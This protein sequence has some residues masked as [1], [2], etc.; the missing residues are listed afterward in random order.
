MRNL[1]I[2]L[3]LAVFGKSFAQ[4]EV[5][6][7]DTKVVD[8]LVYYNN[9]PLT[10][11]LFS[12]DEQLVPNACECTLRIKYENGL[13]NGKYQEWNINGKIKKE[14][15]Y[16]Q[17][18]LQQQK[19]Y[20]ND[21][22]FVETHY[23]SGKPIKEVYYKDGK[24]NKIK[25]Y[26][27][28][29][30]DYTITYYNDKL[31]I[32]KKDF[33][34]NNKLY[35]TEKPFD[36]KFYIKYRKPFESNQ[37]TY[38]VTFDKSFTNDSLKKKIHEYIK[39]RTREIKTDD[40]IGASYQLNFKMNGDNFEIALSGKNDA[41]KNENSFKSVKQLFSKIDE[42]FPLSCRSFSIRKQNES[43]IQ[44]IELGKGSKEGILK[45][46]RLFVYDKNN[47]LKM[48]ELKVIQAYPHKSVCKVISYSEWLKKYINDNKQILVIQ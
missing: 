19:V 43:E 45:K 38:L 31:K 35:K 48:S 17:G 46:M 16:K 11:V 18:V 33:F 4:I 27:Q 14:A 2:F 41:K 5:Y 39:K 30:K 42:L 8:N 36:N 7:S 32:T 29:L 23:K 24:I 10:G 40:K 20:N 47:K 13:R 12:D 1:I 6:Q 37:H 34:V 22:L 21:G 15:V 26:K 3:F 44:Y 9:K 25:E 28:S